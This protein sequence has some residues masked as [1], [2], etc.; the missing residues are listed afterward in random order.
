MG[1]LTLLSCLFE[2]QNKL[3]FFIR[4]I[5][6]V[7][8]LLLQISTAIE[9]MTTETEFFRGKM[10]KRVEWAVCQVT[11]SSLFVSCI[12]LLGLN[13]RKKKKKDF[14]TCRIHI[15]PFLYFLPDTDT[16]RKREH[17][18]DPRAVEEHL[19]LASEAC[20]IRPLQRGKINSLCL[21]HGRFYQLC[22]FIQWGKLKM[23]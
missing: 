18:Y 10:C 20:L 4:N 21:Q 12:H 14:S 5:V 16:T 1:E 17:G 3:N 7:I 23:P 19:F 8:T 22:I 6:T 15:L 13:G 11:E 2:Q 9:E